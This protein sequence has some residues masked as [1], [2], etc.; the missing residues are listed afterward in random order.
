MYVF[1]VFSKFASYNHDCSMG[2][3]HYDWWCCM[4][5]TNSI[6]KQF[7]NYKLKFWKKEKTNKKSACV[8]KCE[9]SYLNK[10]LFTEHVQTVGGTVWN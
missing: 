7:S 4:A 5:E 6:V 10:G 8:L 9:L 2:I 1:Q 3:Y